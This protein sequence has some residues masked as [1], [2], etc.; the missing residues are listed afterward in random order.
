[1]RKEDSAL[2][3]QRA[4]NDLCIRGS[5]HGHPTSGRPL[6]CERAV[7]P[8]PMRG[9]VILRAEWTA[10]SRWTQQ[11]RRRMTRWLGC[12]PLTCCLPAI[13]EG[14]VDPGIGGHVGECVLKA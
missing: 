5:K 9:S 2:T 3:H 13:R 1:M 14:D 10:T 11:G 6:C 7:V 8:A 4:D 12:Q